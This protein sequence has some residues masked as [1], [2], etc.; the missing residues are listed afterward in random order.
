[1][2]VY[3]EKGSGLDT[4]VG[5]GLPDLTVG[6]LLD[7]STKLFFLPGDGIRINWQL[8]RVRSGRVGWRRGLQYRGSRVTP[9]EGRG[10]S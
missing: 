10:L 8:V 2:D 4:L 3:A 1:V 9:V 7:D 6:Q 5:I